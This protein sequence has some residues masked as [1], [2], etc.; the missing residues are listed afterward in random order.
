MEPTASSPTSP[1]AGAG[2]RDMPGTRGNAAAKLCVLLGFLVLLSSSYY[3]RTEV[4]ALN[5]IRFSA[6][7]ARADYEL[8]RL[9]V[10]YPERVER[11]Q[12]ELKNH[13]PLVE[14]Y[15]KLSE[16]YRKDIVKYLE[17]TKDQSQT[18]P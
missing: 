17:L 2:S 10:T 3:L 16:V 4:L 8:K 1:G 18:Q 12:V 11:H 9:Q 6:D 15:E 7:E 14:H 5:R 13:A